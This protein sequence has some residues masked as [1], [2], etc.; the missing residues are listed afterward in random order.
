MSAHVGGTLQEALYR[1]TLPGTPARTPVA[2]CRWPQPADRPAP[3]RRQCSAVTAAARCLA[4][5]SGRT[6][7]CGAQTTL[8]CVAHLRWSSSRAVQ[9]RAAYISVSHER[10]GRVSVQQVVASKPT[11]WRLTALPVAQQYRLSASE[12]SPGV[13]TCQPG[14]QPQQFLP[15]ASTAAQRTPSAQSPLHRSRS[16]VRCCESGATQR[17]RAQT[18]QVDRAAAR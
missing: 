15:P 5:P 8:R 11:L 3:H 2:P 12:P 10:T 9:V 16:A 4:L 7:R 17:G 6:R 14:R 18:A 13:A 1:A